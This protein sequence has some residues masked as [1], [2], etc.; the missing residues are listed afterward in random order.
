MTRLVTDYLDNSANLFP[1]KIALVDSTQT[2][3]FKQWQEISFHIAYY[4]IHN[5]VNKCPIAI[6]MDKSVKQLTVFTGIA[7]SGNY[8]VPLDTASP[9]TRIEKIL[10]TLSPAYIIADS[11]YLDFLH[12]QFPEIPTIKYDD[13]LNINYARDAIKSSTNRIIDT[14]PLYV[15]FT[16]GS[17]GLPKGV[18]ISHKSV[19]SYTEWGSQTFPITSNTII[20]NQTPFY[21]S[22]SVLDIYQTL[23]NSCTLY[24]IPKILFSFP[25]KLL[26]YITDKK[27]NLIYWVP[28]ALCLV[29]NLKALGKRDISCLKY[30]LFAGEVMPTKQLNQWRHFLPNAVYANLFGPTE[31]TDICTYY[32]IDKEIPNTEPIPIGSACQNC[33]ILV[34]NENN[35]PVSA[36]E[37]GELC[38]R[39]SILA[40]GYYNDKKKTATSFV[41]NPLNPYYPETIYRT[42]DLVHYRNDGI[43]I[44]DGR[45][46]FQIKH[47]GHR[48]ELGEIETIA[49]SIASIHQ[50][51]CLYNVKKN[52][53][54][55][56]YSG[57]I[58]KAAV[59]SLL[60]QLLPSYMCPNQ[61][62]SLP[63]L[64]LN[65]NGKVDRHY[66]AEAEKE[67]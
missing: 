65:A 54:V 48:I 51:C 37:C 19:I 56:F 64:P 16:S 66:L 29:A 59:G 57:K 41:Q 7:Y 12:T 32:I 36:N 21:F 1:N 62:I 13:L 9:L 14:D 35:K 26:E 22:M 23:K 4:L 58:D 20:G 24:I 11:K 50:V 40:Y 42:G 44:Y 15:L 60:K 33:E 25:I 18:T 45:K 55:L 67:Y 8:Y 39:G 53:I 10:K 38:V 46:D 5:S 17:T 47:M 43:L 27:I 52:Y 6:F 2:L 63:T 31:V 28:S 34:L 30:V 49:S 3:T 61:I